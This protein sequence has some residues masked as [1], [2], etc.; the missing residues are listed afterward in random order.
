MKRARK[1]IFILFG[2]TAALLIAAVALFFAVTENVTLDPKKLSSVTSCVRVFDEHGEEI[3]TPQTRETLSALPAHL[4]AAFVSVEDKRFYSHHGLDY[5]RIVK[6]AAKN[7]FSLSFREGASTISQQL[8]KNTHLSGEKTLGRKLREL[9]LARALERRFSKEEILEY[10]LNSIY[11]GHSAFGIGD[12][13][14]YYF[15]KFASDLTPAESATLAA[16]VRSP[17]RYS[18]FK[19]PEKCLARRNYVLGLMRGQGVLTEA[20]YADAIRT[21]L[22]SEPAPEASGNAYL[23]RVYEEIAQRFPDAT[24]GEELR[25]YTFWDR[26]LQKILESV[27][28]D[29]DVCLLVRENKTGG[30]AAL[31]STCGTPERLPASTAK[32]LAVYAPALE[33]NLIAPATPL[34]DE[35]IDFGGYSP[36]NYGGTYGGY[37]SARHALAYSVNVPAVKLLNTLGTDRAAEY[38]SRMGLHVPEQDRTLALALGGM[39]KGFSLPALADAYATFAAKGEYAPSSAIARAENASGTLYRFEPQKVRAFSEDVCALMND[40]LQTAVKEGTAKKLSSL[41]FPLCA[42]TGT[43][44]NE[45]GNTDAYTIAYTSDHTVAVW[46][47]NRDNSPIAATGGGLPANEALRILQSLYHSDPPAP[48]FDADVVRIGIDREE[49]EQRHRILLAD[50]AQP[51]YL[52]LVESFR[53]SALP[54]GQS[55][56]FSHPTIETPQIYLKNS[57]VCI[58]LCQT[59]YYDYTI[60]R[61]DGEEKKTIYSGKYRKIVCDNSIVSGKSYVY[62]VVPSFAGNV[63]EPVTLPSVRTGNHEALPDH[64]WEN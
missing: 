1:I 58:E 48:F 5:R 39:S 13:A 56:R 30:L 6:A 62:T 42:K 23:A 40:M 60:I 19:D 10:Y 44:A 2:S 54:E 3:Q 11:F 51:E 8:I 33:E 52:S 7:L 16:L 61:D 43:G 49:Y 29:S 12:A 32:P 57:S 38:L 53:K 18:P 59:Q 45:N 25:V 4:S 9:R 46:M 64:W 27:Q 14:H 21:P 22:P 47:G 17:N 24:S 55:R 31:H 63:G 34:L 20:E 28:C 37:M 50:P 41:P 15:G 36:S 26:S 35:K